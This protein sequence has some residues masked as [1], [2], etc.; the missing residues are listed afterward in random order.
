VITLDKRL[1]FKTHTELSHK[2]LRTYVK[3]YSIFQ[4]EQIRTNAKNLLFKALI[5]SVLTYA[6]PIWLDVA[7]SY[8]QKLHAR[9]PFHIQTLREIA[10]YPDE[11]HAKIIEGH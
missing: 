10:Y 11:K 6:C 2:T 3:P 1:T 4:S 9:Q 7:L 8:F 5:R